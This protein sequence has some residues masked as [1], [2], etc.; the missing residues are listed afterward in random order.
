MDHPDFPPRN[1]QARELP[2]LRVEIEHAGGVEVM[3]PN[4]CIAL[5][6]LDPGRVLA[7]EALAGRVSDVSGRPAI[8]YRAGDVEAALAPDEMLRLISR[9][10]RPEEFFAL[11]R[12]YGVAFEWHADFQDPGTGHPLQPLRSRR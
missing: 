4:T 1:R 7:F 6:V 8:L 2:V 10:L 3:D 11:R 12:R 9:D 5:A